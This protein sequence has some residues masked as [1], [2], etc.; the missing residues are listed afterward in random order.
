MTQPAEQ[1]TPQTPPAERCRLRLRPPAR[2]LFPEVEFTAELV[3]E[4]TVVQ[5]PRG[6]AHADPG[7]WIV[8]AVDPERSADDARWA[9][10][11]PSALIDVFTVVREREP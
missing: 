11:T 7:D 5:T 4:A 3:D 8:R 9:V 1:P 10:F 6:P 2:D